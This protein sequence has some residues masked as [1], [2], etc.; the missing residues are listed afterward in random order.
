MNTALKA[1]FA[2]LLMVA[3]G[4]SQAALIVTTT[5]DPD[6]LANTLGGGGITISN[7]TLT[8][9]STQQG[10]FTGGISAGIGIESGVILTS[11]DATLAPGPNTSDGAGDSLGTSGD[12]A[13]DTLVAPNST[14]DAN[15]LEFNFTSTSG[16]LFFS[17]VFASEEYNEFVGSQFNDV[18]AFYVDGVNIAVIPGTSTPVAINNVNCGSDGSGSG[19]SNCSLFNNNDLD[20]GGPLFNLQYDGFTDVFLASVTGLAPGTHTIRLA[21]AD[22]G[23]EILDSAV[24]LQAG[25]FTSTPPNGSVPEPATLALLGLGLAGLGFARRRKNK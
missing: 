9:A 2:A 6:A 17:Y 25:S 23:D 20:D 5:N 7:A 16:S 10:T 8:G 14:N 3:S 12:S 24:F 21:I 15:I 1:S 4:L 13:L 11:G 19:G 18:F 22:T